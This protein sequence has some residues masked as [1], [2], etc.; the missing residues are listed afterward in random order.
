M[1][2]RGKRIVLAGRFGGLSKGEAKRGL[3]E[4]G[5]RVSAAVSGRT[6]F[7]FAH[8]AEGREIEEA[9]KRNLPIFDERALRGVLGYQE[10]FDDDRSGREPDL[11]ALRSRLLEVERERGITE[12]HRAATR[13]VRAMDGVRLRH[14]YG[15]QTEFLASALSPCGRYLAT[16]SWVG[17]DFDAGGTL[18]IWELAAGRCVNVLERIDGG[19]GWPD[20]ER[21]IQWS[22]DGRRIGLAYSTNMV[23]VFDPF[24][25]LTYGRPVAECSVTDGASR[26][27]VWALAPDGRRAFVASGSPCEVSGCVVP[28]EWGELMWTS[29]QATAPHPFLLAERVREDLRTEEMDEY[30]E[31]AIRVYDWVRWSRD[32]ARLQAVNSWRDRNWGDGGQAFVIDVGSGQLGW[33]A[34]IGGLAAWSPDDRLLAHDGNGLRFL[35]ASTGLPIGGEDTAGRE[36]V[37]ALLWGMRGDTPRLAAVVREDNDAGAEPGVLVYDDGRYRFRLDVTPVET[38]LTDVDTW[39]WAPSGEAGACLTGEGRVEVWSLADD[40]PRRL[41]TLD[42][43]SATAGVLWGADDVLVAVGDTTL[44]FLRAG[45][46]EVLGDFA[47]L[48]EPQAPRPLEGDDQFDAHHFALDDETWCATFPSGV[49]IAPDGRRGTLDDVLA[50][51]VGQRLAWPVRWGELDVV[52]DAR[53]AGERLGDRDDGWAVRAYAEQ[54]QPAE[55]EASWPPNGAATVEDVAR[56]A[57]DSVADL[58]SRWGVHV[59]ENLRLAARLCARRGAVTEAAALVA[60]VPGLGERVAASA[61]VTMVLARAG[62][63]DDARAAF[64]L[65]G[66]KAALDAGTDPWEPHETARVS[67]ALGGAYQALGDTARADAWFDRAR[68]AIEPEAN[69]WQ[70]R[71]AVI[72]ALTECRREDEARELWGPDAWEPK[73]PRFASEPSNSYAEP[74]L[75]YLAR[76]G[77]HAL[78]DEFLTAWETAAVRRHAR[79]RAE[80][81]GPGEE[82][83]AQDDYLRTVIARVATKNVRGL[84]GSLRPA[85]E[86]LTPVTL[87]ETDIAQLT[88]EYDELLRTPRSGRARPTDLLIQRAARCGHIGAVL[89]LLG[90]LSADDFNDRPHS[91]FTALWLATTGQSTE[92]W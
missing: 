78:Y 76:T 2:L 7:V 61:E 59:S 4:L 86:H 46:G 45:S 57:L 84:A 70:N 27:P 43:P 40:E 14:P 35:D 3:E 92:P 53:T 90:R 72:W 64:A 65:A 81:L 23:G 38:G 11:L 21:T 9:W 74:W 34:E 31:E 42:A 44:R 88:A 51:T 82:E 12:E 6:D 32:G 80:L 16:G 54:A 58:E 10:G 30:E 18:Q 24:S 71:L 50:W 85:A 5:A 8:R 41:R 83:D 13:E 15:H 62:R 75:L 48:R 47:F 91:A 79:S 17:D 25:P 60:A 63:P 26:P 33:L 73:P 49:V 19:V 39:A 20:R 68:A 56:A 37:S 77:R 67:A 89:D 36:G 87:A 22:A 69:P 55:E 29:G 1:D 52:P 66:T 28:L